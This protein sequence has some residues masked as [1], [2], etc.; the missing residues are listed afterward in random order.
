MRPPLFSG[1]FCNF[2][3]FYNQNFTKVEKVSEDGVWAYYACTPSSGFL[4]APTDNLILDE[5]KQ[6]KDCIWCTNWATFSSFVRK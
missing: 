4:A 3:S 1:F 6:S 5:K 2:L